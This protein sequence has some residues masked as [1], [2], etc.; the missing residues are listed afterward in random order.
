[1]NDSKP[2]RWRFELLF[3][4]LALA[5]MGL[6]GRVG[7]LQYGQPATQLAARA[8]FQLRRVIVLPARPGNIFARTRGGLVPLAGSRQ[9][10]SCYAD[11]EMIGEESFEDV[12]AKVAQAAGASA[13]ELLAKIFEHRDRRFAWLLRDIT[14]EQTQAIRKLKL[15]GVEISYEWRRD[16]P[17]G[18][19]ASQVMGYRRVDGVAGEGLELQ[20][21]RWLAARD[22]VKVIRTDATRR[23][24][25]A[26]VEDLTPPADGKHV[27][28]SIDAVI[29]G[30][31]QQAMTEAFE[32]F[33]AQ[34]VMGVVMD[35]QT[36]AIL[37]MGSIPNY[38]P[39]FYSGA[40]DD[41]RCNRPITHP[42]EPG[43][44]FKPF[45]A[46]G[47]VG[48]EKATLNTTFFCAYG[49]YNA[50][51]GGT[52]RDFPGEHFGVLPLS[53]IVIHSS[54]IGMARVGEL[55]GNDTLYQIAHAFGF[56]QRTGIDLPG[57]SPGI[58]LPVRDE[59]G[60]P[61]W[62][63]YD[64]L[65][66]P[67]GQGP[68]SVTALQLATAFSA[69]AN[70]GTLMKPRVVDRIIDA[71]GKIIYRSQPVV[72]RRVLR[73]EVC[74]R[75]IDEV[76]TQVVERGTGKKAKLDRWRVFGKT[77]TG[78]IGGPHGYEDRAYT[79]T[80]VGGAPASNPEVVCVISVYRPDY[81]K[82]HTGGQVAAPFVR[83]V[84]GKTL[85]YMDVP[86]DS[87]AATAGHDRAGDSGA[88][89]KHGE[90]AW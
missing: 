2:S 61:A 18:T 37:A 38:D 85:A 6:G 45:V 44:A 55:L 16:Y 19:L 5:L 42:Y 41:E 24:T 7:Y 75:F 87:S 54:N 26:E 56:G 86:P 67:F 74:R 32:Q 76:L 13:R 89:A 66:L 17:N 30:Y 88:P 9:I 48:L 3:G 49:L 59:K 39:N 15:K 73:P 33:G 60:K 28:L 83:E 57:E 47:A 21:D 50:P 63:T 51:R 34:A 22:G 27:V 40:L 84:L 81:S 46:I 1:M 53:E 70:G 12:T 29:Q 8:E 20:A 62:T 64:T 31:L 90:G 79:G 71:E 65:R 43:S 35:P 36:G 52:I 14:K 82:G 78:Q 11:P 77:G 80:F 10:P 72:N 4:L 69:I 23:G 68:V 25:Y 58:L